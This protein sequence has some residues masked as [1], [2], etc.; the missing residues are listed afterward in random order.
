M[1][2]R[3]DLEAFNM[4]DRDMEWKDNFVVTTNGH[5]MVKVKKAV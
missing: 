2:R 5:L 1:V 4:S 3:F